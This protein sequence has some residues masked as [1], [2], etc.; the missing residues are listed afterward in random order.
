MIM[1]SLCRQIQGE[2]GTALLASVLL[3]SLITGAGQRR[4]GPFPALPRS[5]EHTSEL[6]SRLHSVCRLL[7]EKKKITRTNRPTNRG[8]SSCQARPSSPNCPPPRSFPCG[9]YIS[10]DEQKRLES[11]ART[12]PTSPTRDA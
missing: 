9:R 7:L 11:A 1:K 10:S 2:P 5:E 4:A 6:Q 8:S 12:H 3:I